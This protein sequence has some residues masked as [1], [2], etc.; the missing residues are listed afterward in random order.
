MN[1]LKIDPR[2]SILVP[3]AHDEPAIRLELYRD[4]FSQ[5]AA[6]AYNTSVERGFLHRQFSISASTQEIVGCGVD[7]PPHLAPTSSASDPND[8]DASDAERAAQ[9]G[10]VFR[11]RH[12]LFNPFVLY[13]GRIDP[14]KGCEEL[15]RVLQHLRSGIRRC[16]AGPHG[17]QADADPG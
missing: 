11:R 15:D 6:I 1:G 10:A 12:R 8:D 7:L 3:T 14:G 16:D 4:V 2:R 5:P 9:R 17:G 13:G